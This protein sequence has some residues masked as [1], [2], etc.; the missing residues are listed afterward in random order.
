M[1]GLGEGALH[2]EEPVGDGSFGGYWGGQRVARGHPFGVVTLGQ[3]TA[4]LSLL[5]VSATAATDPAGYG[6]TT[7]WRNTA[8]RLP[9]PELR[10]LIAA[11]CP[12]MIENRMH[13][14]CRVHFPQLSTLVW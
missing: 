4:R 6:P 10:G 9:V 11:D 5:D 8:R 2:P 13:E 3:P 14:V 1:A 7:C 12:R